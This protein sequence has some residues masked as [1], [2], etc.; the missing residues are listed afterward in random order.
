MLSLARKSGEFIYL[1]LSEE[2]DPS[3]PISEFF[4]SGPIVIGV[5]DIQTN[6]VRI[7][8]QA[9][10]AFNIIRSE[11]IDKQGTLRKVKI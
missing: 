2:I 7:G 3:T 4:K 5:S 10:R 6:Q 1:S 9:D 8:I 11:L